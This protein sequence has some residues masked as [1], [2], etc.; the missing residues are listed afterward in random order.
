[1]ERE[2]EREVG[3]IIL[4]KNITLC[5]DFTAR[6]RRNA[7]LPFSLVHQANKEIIKRPMVMTL[8]SF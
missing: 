8:Q 1:L 7:G 4:T 6:E 5:F 3:I 2:R